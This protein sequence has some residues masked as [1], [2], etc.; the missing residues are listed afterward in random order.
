MDI[1]V[2]C[3]GRSRELNPLAVSNTNF[4]D[5]MPAIFHPTPTQ[6]RTLVPDGYKIEIQL[7]SIMPNNFNSFL[8]MMMDDPNFKAARFATRETLVQKILQDLA[9]KIENIK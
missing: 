6:A 3:V 7:Q 4:K 5:K 2:D 1:K 9:T 8:Y